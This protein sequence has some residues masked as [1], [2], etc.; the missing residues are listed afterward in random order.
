MVLLLLKEQNYIG[1]LFEIEAQDD[2]TI[3]L[4][5][6]VFVGNRDVI[7]NYTTEGILKY[8]T[9]LFRMRFT[10]EQFS[11]F[12]GNN[13][14]KAQGMVDN[15]FTLNGRGI[16][17]DNSIEA[18]FYP[19]DFENED[20]VQVAYFNKGDI[21]A[22]GKRKSEDKEFLNIL[23][24]LVDLKDLYNKNRTSDL[25]ADFV[26]KRKR[27]ESISEINV[28]SFNVGQGNATGVFDKQFD[29]IFYYDLGGGAYWNK[30]TYP[31][32]K[33]FPVNG[34]PL[35][36]LS[37]WDFDHYE[38]LK[39][40]VA[41]YNNCNIMAPLQKTT[42]SIRK[43]AAMISTNLYL[44]DKELGKGKNYGFLKM[45]RCSGKKRNDSGIGMILDLRKNDNIS[46]ILLPGDSQYFFI[47]QG[48]EVDAICVSHHGGKIYNKKGFPKPTERGNG[49]CVYSYGQDNTYDHP[50]SDSIQEHINKGWGIDRFLKKYSLSTTTHNVIYSS[51]INVSA[52]F[53]ASNLSI[54]GTFNSFHGLVY[55]RNI[56]IRTVLSSV[57][58]D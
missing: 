53:N 41:R 11:N 20:Q 27:D 6:D 7:S 36:I 38:S 32:V 13:V 33:N 22:I 17:T 24:T 39:A 25:I 35:I 8:E 52:A 16:K 28:V 46:K 29:P 12:F 48:K 56:R 43:F 51:D 55:N 26:E 40:K 42:P 58:N 4:F 15:W 1:N 50:L 45:F 47:K 34:N 30:K 31:V 57:D 54:L 44:I 5:F 14:S 23:N 3:W 10:N 49:Y 18:N 21:T 19:F 37:H 9:G 2:D